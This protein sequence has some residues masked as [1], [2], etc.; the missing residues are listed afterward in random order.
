M[1]EAEPFGMQ[2]LARETLN[3]FRQCR[4]DTGRN[5]LP[6][7]VH[8]VTEQRIID[9]CHVDPN[10]VRTTGFQLHPDQAMV[11]KFTRHLEMRYCWFAAILD[12]HFFSI[13]RMTA[14]ARLDSST[15]GHHAP[16]YGYILT[17]N[18]A[19]LQLLDQPVVRT[20]IARYH[21]HAG[22]VLVE[23]M[24]YAGARQL[25]QTRVVR[26][27]AVDQCSVPM[28]GR[29]MNHQVSRFVD[30]KDIFILVQDFKIDSLRLIRY[31]VHFGNVEFD[32]VTT[33]YLLPGFTGFAVNANESLLYPLLYLAARVVGQQL[34]Q[35]LVETTTGL[36]FFNLETLLN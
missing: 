2:G 9:V 18:A 33:E 22:G 24:H 12:R 5:T 20:Q 7:A 32:Q 36:T 34:L 31:N 30:D 15:R 14:N 1:F 8:A 16:G 3:S 13:L 23:S 11:C 28:P 27:Q 26:E 6:P 21:H 4:V 17:L 25:L 29:G 19:R 35:S 10:L